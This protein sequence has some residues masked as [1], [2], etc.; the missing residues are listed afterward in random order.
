MARRITSIISTT[1]LGTPTADPAT[2]PL[3]DHDVLAVE[4][5]ERCELART[6]REVK[7]VVDEWAKYRA[8]HYSRAQARDLPAIAAVVEELLREYGLLKPPPRAG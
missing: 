3:A 5:G 8:D 7:T 6:I 4:H 2:Q 1:P